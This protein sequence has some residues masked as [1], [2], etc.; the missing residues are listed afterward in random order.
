MKRSEANAEDLLRI[1]ALGWNNPG[2]D[3]YK[4]A[5]QSLTAA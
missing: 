2:S 5:A 3:F 1:E 4:C